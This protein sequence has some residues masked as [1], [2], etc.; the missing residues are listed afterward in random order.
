M[1]KVIRSRTCK[2]QLGKAFYDHFVKQRHD[3]R[4]V[5]KIGELV[6]YGF[7]TIRMGRQER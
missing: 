1:V 4:L 5:L 6:I 7:S 3:T 2:E